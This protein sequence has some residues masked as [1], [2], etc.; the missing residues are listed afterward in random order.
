MEGADKYGKV[1]QTLVLD[2]LLYQFVRLL[3]N[4]KSPIGKCYV[5]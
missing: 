2:I 5:F 1:I 3:L 4:L